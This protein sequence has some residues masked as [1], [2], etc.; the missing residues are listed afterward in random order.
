[1]FASLPQVR[2]RDPR[3]ESLEVLK[4]IQQ[5]AR[6]LALARDRARVVARGRRDARARVPIARDADARVVVVARAREG[7]RARRAA[8]LAVDEAFEGVGEPGTAALVPGVPRR[9]IHGDAGECGDANAIEPRSRARRSRLKFNRH[10]VDRRW[11]RSRFDRDREVETRERRD[12]DA[13]G[14][15]GARGK[16]GISLVLQG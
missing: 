3:V 12:G 2:H 10:D 8:R 6:P 5:H 16:G 4:V 7:V 1:M 15:R 9:A 14:A 13:R 11:T